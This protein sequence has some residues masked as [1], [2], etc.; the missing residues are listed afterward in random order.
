MKKAIGLAFLF[1][2]IVFGSLDRSEH[3][4]YHNGQVAV[5]FNSLYVY[6]KIQ[7]IDIILTITG[8]NEPGQITIERVYVKY[9]AQ[10]HKHR[11]QWEPYTIAYNK[12]IQ[13]D[14]MYYPQGISLKII[15]N[16]INWNASSE[17]LYVY[18]TVSN[19]SNQFIIVNSSGNW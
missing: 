2:L 6:R 16:Y 3:T 19:S 17:P 1:M 14:D 12:A 8:Y 4:I 13:L 9:G 11:L 5:A 10:D 15:G 18:L 7:T